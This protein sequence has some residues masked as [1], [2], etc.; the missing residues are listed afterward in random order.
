MINGETHT[1]ESLQ[2]TVW[3]WDWWRMRQEIKGFL[4]K[5]LLFK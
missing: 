4:V 5:G 3:R 1:N 2:A